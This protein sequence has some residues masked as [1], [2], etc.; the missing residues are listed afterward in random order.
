M[1]CAPATCWLYAM[2]IAQGL[3][4]YGVTAVFRT[5]DFEIFEGRAYGSN[6]GPLVVALNAGRA[7]GRHLCEHQLSLPRTLDSLSI[8]TLPPAHLAPA[9]STVYE[10][11][12]RT[13]DPYQETDD[14]GPYAG[15]YPK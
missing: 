2:V 7:T 5:V 8:R 4:G 10:C 9:R 11:P 12:P 1:K 3:L 13:H 14:V 6:L 15:R